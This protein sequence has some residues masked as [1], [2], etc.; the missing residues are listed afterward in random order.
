LKA[1][2]K[3]LK[4]NENIKFFN[5]NLETIEENSLQ[6]KSFQTT[7]K[8]VTIPKESSSLFV[9]ISLQTISNPQTIQKS[10]LNNRT[11]NKSCSFLPRKTQIN[12]TFPCLLQKFIVT[13]SANLCATKIQTIWMRQGSVTG[14][15]STSTFALKS[16][17]YGFHLFSF[18]QA[19]DNSALP[20]DDCYLRV[21]GIFHVPHSPLLRCHRWWNQFNHPHQNSFPEIRRSI[22]E[23]KLINGTLH[24]IKKYECTHRKRLRG[25]NNKTFY[26]SIV[27][28]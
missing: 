10:L 6:L 21:S 2:A 16:L 11:P 12:P 22:R 4:L 15:H 18:S 8:L 17:I 25:F 28:I 3:S 14:W 26:E 27:A 13:V 23:M 24:H 7:I 19:F 5:E 1:S 9:P 20:D